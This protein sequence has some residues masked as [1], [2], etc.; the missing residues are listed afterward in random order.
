MSKKSKSN[1]PAKRT[2]SP[3]PTT[4]QP[5]ITQ[6]TQH[7][8][9]GPIPHPEVLQLYDATIPGAAERILAMAE[10]D[11]SHQIEIE[12]SALN[13]AAAEVK[14]GQIF[15][16]IIGML[17]FLTSIIALALGSEKTAMALGGT[18]VIGLVTVF[19]TGRLKQ[20]K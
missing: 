14:R 7:Q 2:F 18:T 8:F 5:Q 15:G 19:V 20:P 13:H 6:V 9:S 4:R 1:S 3:A 16:L 10:K 11:A 12:K 17:A